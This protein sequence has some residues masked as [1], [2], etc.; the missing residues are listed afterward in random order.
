MREEVNTQEPA[1]ELLSRSRRDALRIH[2]QQILACLTDGE[3]ANTGAETILFQQLQVAASKIAHD[4][5]KNNERAF[6]DKEYDK[7]KKVAAFCNAK[8]TKTIPTDQN[9]LG[10]AGQ[11]SMG[12]STANAIITD[13]NNLGG[14]VALNITQMLNSTVSAVAGTTTATM[15][16]A[17]AASLPG[18]GIALFGL[19]AVYEAVC[20]GKHDYKRKVDGY[21]KNEKGYAKFLEHGRWKQWVNAGAW[22]TSGAVSIALASAF[23]PVMLIAMGAALLV[24]STMRIVHAAVELNKLT[25][26]REYLRN[27]IKTLK[28]TP[29]TTDENIQDE[30]TAFEK[31]EEKITENIRISKADITATSIL[32]IGTITGIALLTLTAFG[33]C[34][35]LV[36]ILAGAMLLALIVLTIVKNHKAIGAAF[37]T[38]FTQLANFFKCQKRKVGPAPIDNDTPAASAPDERSENGNWSDEEIESS[39]FREE[40]APTNNQQTKT[41]LRAMARTHRPTGRQGKSQQMSAEE[42]EARQSESDYDSD[43]DRDAIFNMDEDWYDDEEASPDNSDSS[44]PRSG[45]SS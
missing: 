26:H 37:K 15:A 38:M 13:M 40:G 32:T 14:I 7:W 34:G 24:T 1:Q 4:Y 29:P 45:N 8:I 19:Q 3:L 25:T 42:K 21:Q 31:L 12:R 9:G 43:S 10:D 36:G 22:I 16:A 39:P 44:T 20:L 5:A 18:M 17:S 28:E 33:V 11:H 2:A 27:Q 35:P 30:I 23:P 6:H 41:T